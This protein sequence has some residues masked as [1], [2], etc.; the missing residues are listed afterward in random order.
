MEILTDEVFGIS[1]ELPLN[2]VSRASADE[3]LVGNLGRDRH[4]VIYGSSK[5]GKTSLRKHCLSDDDY[6]VVHCSNKWQLNDLHSAILKKCGFEITLS[7]E[8]SQSGKNKIVAKIAAKFFGAQA[9]GEYSG[10]RE[11]KT[12]VETKPLELDPE[13]VNDIITALNSVDFE[14][15]IVLEDFHYLPVETQKDFSVALK[16]FHENSKLCFIVIGVWLD[17]NKLTV[18]NGDLT[19]RVL[20]IDA[21]KW[22]RNEL[23]EVIDSGAR[24]LN[25]EFDKSF[26]E[27]LLDNCFSSVSIVQEVCHR[28]CIQQGVTKEQ[29][30]TR[31]IGQGIDAKGIIQNVV[32]QQSGRFNSFITQFADGFQA[33]ELEMHR[34]LLYPIL[35]TDTLQL[36]RGIRQKDIREMLRE[37][38]PRGQD[39]NQGNVTQALQST[40]ALQI[41]K[42]IKPMILDYDQTN[43][44]LNI[45]DRSFLI[46]LDNQERRDLLSIADLV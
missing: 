20:S 14:K 45:V 8:K 12:V 22:N 28:C 27:N 19:G 13:D 34:W 29:A 35:V 4:L 3:V 18:Y 6:I 43:L 2:Y 32:G 42:D 23:E 37:H 7:N 9:S 10:E 36:G 24:L 11:K 26:K 25:I 44:R 5:Q 40:A 41:K 33:T 17:E 1:R 16:A 30:Q 31:V 38:H 46:W 39:L 15:F 21:D